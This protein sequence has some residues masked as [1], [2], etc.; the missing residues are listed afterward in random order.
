MIDLQELL[1]K[2]KPFVL[3]W[4]QRTTYLSTPL[5]STAWDGDA[6]STTAKT[7]IDLSAVFGVPAGVSA[8]LVQVV[9]RDSGSAAN[10]CYV[11]LAPVSTPYGSGV[12]CSG[13]PNDTYVNQTLIV[14]CNAD[15]DIY[16]QVAASGAG[17]MDIFLQIEGWTI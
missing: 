1:S 3:G 11:V 2:I 13:L 8:V 15:G 7:L 9:L 12:R 4:M 5:T 14:P 6:R 16:Y 10:D 17:T